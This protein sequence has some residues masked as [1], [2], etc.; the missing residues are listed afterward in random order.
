MQTELAKAVV[1]DIGNV[2]IGWNPEQ[3]Y[4]A[5]IGAD[6]RKALFAE[7]DLHAMNDQVDLGGDMAALTSELAEAT[8]QWRDEILMW[9]SDWLKMAAPA[10][11]HSAR[12]LRALRAKGIPVFALSNFGIGTFDIACQA[13]PVLTEFDR[14][15]VSGHMQVI[16]P[17]AQIYQMLEEDSGLSG[18]ELIFTDDRTNNIEA[19][20]ARG[21]QTHTFTG[22]EGWA[23]RL[24]ADGYLTAEEAA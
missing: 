18:A 14:K 12:L 8:P 13:Y 6:R 9:H 7:V 3:H 15:Y 19:A 5:V 2:L 16:K 11:P 22:P 17:D 4:D 10:I 20:A 24:V 1:F 21:W 23:E